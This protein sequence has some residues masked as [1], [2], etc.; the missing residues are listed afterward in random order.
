MNS[1][2]IVGVGVLGTGVMGTSHVETLNR[3]APGTD[4]VAV[5]DADADRAKQVAHSVGAV[6]TDSA[7]ELIENAQVD[8]IVIAAPDAL[9]EELALACLSAGKP[10]LLEKPL[11]TT[12][13]GSRRVVEAE[14]AGGRRLLQLGF[15]RRYDTAFLALR[16]AVLSGRVGQVRAMHCRHR[17]AQAHPTATS[18]GVLVNSMIHEFDH[19]PWL[20][21]DPIAA[22]TVFAPRVPD[23]A[24]KDVQ[25]AVLETLGGVVATVEVSVNAHYGYDVQTEVTG[26]SGTAELTPPYGLAVKQGGLDGREVGDDFVSRFV[27]AY[28]L[29]LSAWIEGVRMEA[30]TGP[31]AWDGYRANTT[32]FAAVRSL[33]GAGR[34]EVP[35]E[36]RPALYRAGA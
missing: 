8:A 15:M 26:T 10:T 12:L 4:V 3:W 25:I 13:E 35:Q 22:V 14:L 33:G 21:D 5:Y 17:N 23:G 20:L 11:A 19:V 1:R 36:S 34:V 18:V 32:A 9:H 31:S 28:R 27:D 24:L 29:E 2:S 6:V 16:E 7:H 30:L